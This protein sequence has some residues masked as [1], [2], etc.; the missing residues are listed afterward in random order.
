[1]TA[2]SSWAT[3]TTEQI[4]INQFFNILKYQDGSC[5][6]YEIASTFVKVMQ[7]QEAQLP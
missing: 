7:K 6:N 1:M 5:Q 4:R 3:S 2:C